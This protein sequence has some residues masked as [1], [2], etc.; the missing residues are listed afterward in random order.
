MP[1][2]TRAQPSSYSHLKAELG[3]C[4]NER[5]YS[6]TVDSKTL[7]P[8]NLPLWRGVV[9]DKYITN[10]LW[11]H[12]G[13]KLIFPSPR[14]DRAETFFESHCFQVRDASLLVVNFLSISSTVLSLFLH[15][16]VYHSCWITVAHSCSQLLYNIHV[17]RDVFCV[18]VTSFDHSTGSHNQWWY[19]EFWWLFLDFISVT[20]LL[21]ALTS[22]K[23][24]KHDS[25]HFPND[26]RK[27]LQIAK[28]EGC[29]KQHEKSRTKT[30]SCRHK[31]HFQINT[32]TSTLLYTFCC[33]GGV[34]SC[35][36][37]PTVD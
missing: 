15:W 8:Q 16:H 14:S 3:F 20:C 13:L 35:I 29:C 27:T 23:T 33:H 31:Q 9:H 21:Q 28:D 5:A 4:S 12:P 22:C 32:T 30:D 24:R 7:Q 36:A 17:L 19:K 34:P 10:W 2:S 1:S 6:V 18:F 25:S 37:V 26:H 11:C